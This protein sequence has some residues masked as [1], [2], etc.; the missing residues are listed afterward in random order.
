MWYEGYCDRREFPF[1][2]VAEGM[3]AENGYV[4]YVMVEDRYRAFCQREELGL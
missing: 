4:I 3:P 1:L 2:P